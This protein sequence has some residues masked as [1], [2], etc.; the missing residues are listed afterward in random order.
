MSTAAR[1]TGPGEA[2]QLHRAA[3]TSVAQGGSHP[4]TL[5]TATLGTATLGT[6]TLD[7]ARL[8]EV[9]S[10]TL[11]AAVEAKARVPVWLSIC[12][13]WLAD[14]RPLSSPL[15]VRGSRAGASI[16]AGLGEK[17]QQEKT[18]DEWF[19][20]L[21][22]NNDANVTVEEVRNYLTA[23]TD[24]AAILKGMGVAN[25]EEAIAAIFEFNADEDNKM[26]SEEFRRRF[27]STASAAVK[28]LFI[29]NDAFEEV[30][31]A[32]RM[33]MP[34]C[35]YAYACAAVKTLRMPLR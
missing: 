28:T 5:G 2:Q 25:V 1:T 30:R 16:V 7:A 13:K 12:G 35:P 21:D 20:L 6:A 31:L 3:P 10:L 24:S 8:D 23:A 17:S 9:M 32:V 27:P 4:A 14:G 22:G 15:R 34:I 11:S 18:A 19:A 29:S 26:S 33:C